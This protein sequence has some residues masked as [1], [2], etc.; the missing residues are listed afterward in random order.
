MENLLMSFLVNHQ[1]MIEGLVLGAVMTHPASLAV[2]LFGLMV[3]IPGV[4][5]WIAAHPDKAKA[6]ADGFDQAI[7]SQIDKYSA[8]DQ[9][10][11]KP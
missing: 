10:A 7:D 5:Q 8:Q 4:G 2:G 11:P 1:Q 3:K 6:F 9:A